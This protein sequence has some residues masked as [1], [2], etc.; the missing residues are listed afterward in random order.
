[1]AGMLAIAGTKGII[2]AIA[3]TIG[4]M[5]KTSRG[6]TNR[7]IL[8]VAETIVSVSAMAVAFRNN[9]SNSSN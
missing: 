5:N 4:I 6:S 2:P 7:D 8:A 3:V 1:M 9:T